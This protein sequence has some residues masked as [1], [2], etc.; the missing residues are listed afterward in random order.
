MADAKICLDDKKRKKIKIERKD[1]KTIA[2]VCY[3]RWLS[4]ISKNVE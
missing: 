3:H 2:C 1:K 4:I